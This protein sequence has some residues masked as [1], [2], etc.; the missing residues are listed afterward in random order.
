MWPYTEEELNWLAAPPAAPA[1]AE[2]PL[3][4][5]LDDLDA[6]LAANDN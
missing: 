6:F 2:S 5:D 3:F 4:G 1:L